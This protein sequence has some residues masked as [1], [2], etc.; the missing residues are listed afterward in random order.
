MHLFDYCVITASH[1]RQAEI[2]RNLLKRRIE[3]GLYPREITFKVY[4]DPPGGRIGSG[5]GTLWALNELIGEEA[6][7][8]TKDFLCDTKILILHAGGESRRL[9]CYAPEGKLFAPV[10]AAS[11]SVFPPIVLDLQLNLYLN[12]PWHEGE[13]VVGSGDVII[14][15]DAESIPEQRGDICGFAKAAPVEQGSHHGVFLLDRMEN[16][17]ADYFQKA[18]SEFLL[19]N[20]AFE[21][22]D[23]CALDIGI[24]SMS[25]R[26]AN[27]F[28]DAAGI[29]IRV[30]TSRNSDQPLIELLK[31][32]AIR[33]DIYLELM[34]ASLA[35][36]SF[37]DYKRRIASRTRLDSRQVKLFYDTFQK[38][39]LHGVLT[40]K[41][42]FLHFGSLTEF[43]AACRSIYTL[44]LMPF[45]HVSDR[46]E[47]KGEITTDLIKYN[48]KGS[49][50]GVTVSPA[51]P[52]FFEGCSD[53]IVDRSGG[54]NMYVGLSIFSGKTEIPSKI[55]IE[56]RRVDNTKIHLIYGIDDT[57]KI[58]NSPDD[59][60][61]CNRPITDWISER[62]LILS[63]I[64]PEG[65][66]RDLLEARLFPA[67]ET[68]ALI[69]GW[70]HA[71]SDP[72]TWRKRFLGV[73]RYSLKELN[74]LA[75]AMNRDQRRSEIRATE[76]RKNIL[77]GKGWHSLSAADMRVI[78][79]AG[80]NTEDTAILRRICKQTDD[81]LLRHYREATLN[82]VDGSNVGAVG[83][84][85]TTIQSHLSFFAGIDRDLS[86][87]HVGVKQ[88]QIV[89]ARCPVRFDL[90]G[91]WT[92]TPPYTNRYG[93][94]VVNIA[95][96][97]NGQPPIQVFV[98]PTKEHRIRIHSIDLGVTETYEKKE[99]ILD[100]T[101][102]SSAFSL[103]K[104]ALCLLG[105]VRSESKEDLQK[106]LAKLGCGIEVTILCA[107]PKGSGLGTSSILG[108]TIL[109]ALNRFFGAQTAQDDLFLQVLEME[110]M[111]TTGGGW[112][113]QIGGVAGGV[114]YVVSQPSAKPLTVIH[115][116]DSFLFTD[117]KMHRCYT[118][119]YTGVT[120]LAK[121]ILQEIVAGVNGASPAYLFTHN[122]LKEL[123]NQTRSAISTRDY[124]AL[125][126]NFWKS[127]L[128][129][130]LMHPSTTNDDIENLLKACRP[131]FLGMKL[132]GAGGGGYA[133]FAS[134]TERQAEELRT[135]LSKQFEDE[136]ARIV[137]FSL[138]QTGLQVSVS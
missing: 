117:E 105:V 106:T 109:G 1:E 136:R 30:G 5:G 11:N 123:A 28:V 33:F 102:P 64:W 54:D 78:F 83:S 99:P 86:P 107:V 41:S 111:L 120:R 62:A 104:A 13:V 38:F 34:I 21:G 50:T 115:Q 124:P 96:N 89:W 65:D 43:P 108:A 125:A 6:A 56:E 93:G 20:A 75:N 71:P 82:V 84:L 25:P 121:N 100:Y 110:Q 59:V 128:A 57:F 66:T 19:R 119:F 15:F 95:A 7:G 94:Q 132:L 87:L 60:V 135:V 29:D 126:R 76:M 9:P 112:Q 27:A 67:S 77:A 14:D 49:S 127:W 32:G 36:L 39:P 61:Y 18:E 130:K 68:E 72:D 47:L 70:W 16:R 53:I 12:Y 26:F 58:V 52:S 88:D 31:A 63:D 90:A 134:E 118:L 8:T 74:D 69:D 80:E 10:P 116:L 97:L 79:G 131:Y 103:P 55:C 37:D 101:H 92:D 35:G 113:D 98:R 4:S 23:E 91:G 81:P 24:V 17:V 114:K 48:S 122:H 133:L 40:R 3:H 137:E 42:T 129:N 85:N 46:G 45:Y 138:N 22:T 51:G 73:K 2:F 44:G